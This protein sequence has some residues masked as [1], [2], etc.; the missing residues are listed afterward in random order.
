MDVAIDFAVSTVS[1]GR[2]W[3][4]ARVWYMQAWTTFVTC[5]LNVNTESSVTPNN[6][7]AS[8][9][10]TTVPATL[11]PAD[12]C[13]PAS[14]WRVPKASVFSGLSNS[15]FCKNHVYTAS[16]QPT[17]DDKSPKVLPRNR[18][19][20]MTLLVPVNN[21]AILGQLFLNEDDFLGALDHKVST[22]I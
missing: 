2:I 4:R 8:A 22:R 12:V 13:V 16:K 20:C 6:F 15:A 5:W 14:H 10:C 7:T 9:K 18:T 11:T 17:S 19:H 1:S 21:H 3:R